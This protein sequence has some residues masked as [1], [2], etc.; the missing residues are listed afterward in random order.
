VA[1]DATIVGVVLVPATMQLLGKASW[2]LRR[3]LDRLL[4]RINVEGRAMNDDDLDDLVREPV[5][6][7][8]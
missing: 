1:I 6:T 3:W 5:T 8:V 2:W 7:G 4:P